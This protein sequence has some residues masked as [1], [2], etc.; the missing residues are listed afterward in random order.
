MADR[1][2]LT[3]VVIF[4]MPGRSKE[5]GDPGERYRLLVKKYETSEGR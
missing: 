4:H 1:G 5:R 2:L 3:I